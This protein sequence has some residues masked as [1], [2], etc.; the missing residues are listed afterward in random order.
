VTFSNIKSRNFVE[1]KL[2]STPIEK[3]LSMICG[4]CCD[5]C[6]P[7]DKIFK[8]NILS[9]SSAPNPD[10]ILWENND[11]RLL[12]FRRI[13]SIAITILILAGCNENI[14]SKI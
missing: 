6:K 1:D 11:S 14:R 7:Q 13:I 2:S 5:C 8:N 4:S 12:F 3:C 10:S 9:I